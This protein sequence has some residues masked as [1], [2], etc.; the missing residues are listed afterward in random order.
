M[1]PT[2]IPDPN[3]CRYC[4]TPR[5]LHGQ[6]Y[7]EEVDWHF[8]AP[9]TDTQ[10]LARMRARRAARKAPTMTAHDAAQRLAD[11]LDELLASVPV[12]AA[13]QCGHALDEH[14]CTLAAGHT[15]RHAAA[16]GWTWGTPT[17]PTPHDP[18]AWANTPTAFALAAEENTRV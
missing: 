14:T 18:I 7:A 10:I 12:P 17:P 2:F 1:K 13:R 5:G 16:D 4:D 3:A 8:W 15:G 6:S 11:A 9:P